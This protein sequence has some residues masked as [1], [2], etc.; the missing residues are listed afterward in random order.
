MDNKEVKAI[1]RTK[2]AC[3]ECRKNKRKCDGQRPSCS[4]CEKFDRA[5]AYAE[6]TSNKRKYADEGL[7]YSLQNRIAVL[8]SVVRAY[9]EAERPDKILERSS[10]LIRESENDIVSASDHVSIYTQA[11]PPILAQTPTPSNPSKRTQDT[12]GRSQVAMEELASLMLSMDVNGQAEPSFMMTSSN[13]KTSRLGSESFNTGDFTQGVGSVRENNVPQDFILSLQDKQQLMYLFMENFNVFHQ[14]LDLEDSVSVVNTDCN[15]ERSDVCFRNYAIFSVGAYFSEAPEL[16]HIGKI[17][18]SLAE[19]MLLSCIRNNTS[20]LIVQGTSLLAWREITLGNDDMAYNFIAMATGLI[21][22][23]AH[24]VAVLPDA[25]QSDVEASM[26][27]RKIRSFW[28]YFSV[29]RLVTSSLGMNCTIHW[30]RVRTECF[31]SL[32][33]GRATVDDVAHDSFCKLWHLW[34]SCMDQVHAF[35]WSELTSDERRSLAVRSHQTLEGFY[36]EL[37][38]RIHLNKDNMR[39]SVVWFQLSYHAALLLIHRPFLN[40][41]TGSVTLGLALRSATSAA[42]SIA[43]ILRNYRTHPGFKSVGP[44]VQEFVLAAAVIHLLNATAGRTKL[45]RQ[46][47][48]GL[49]SCLDWLEGMDSK[50]RVQVN[51]SITR[52]RELAHRWKV[53]WALPLHL[54]Y[55][56]ESTLPAQTTTMYPSSSTIGADTTNNFVATTHTNYNFD[57]SMDPILA[58]IDLFQADQYGGALDQITNSWDMEAWD[59]YIAN[60]NFDTGT[61]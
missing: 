54:S 17:C 31:Y 37:D 18:V 13:K 8:E 35:S 6:E 16:Q 49:R 25:S 59:L 12:D 47:S 41:P 9:R 60:G 40:E 29:D 10:R 56:T 26:M 19:N 46:S 43:R 11:P 55:P 61:Y 23:R 7:I 1:N 42:S 3:R 2:I 38:G 30:Q 32:V 24:H 4:L 5:C 53:A 58:G 15:Q 27:K 39:P 33:Q 50:W 51:R 44:Q 52:I 36:N 14:Y 20:D 45:G 28:A 21:L 48:N 22:H 57:F 34:D